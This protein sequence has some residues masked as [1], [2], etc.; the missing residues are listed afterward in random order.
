M[1]SY[2][3]PV[4]Y[5]LIVLFCHLNYCSQMYTFRRHILSNR[6]RTTKKSESNIF[7]ILSGTVVCSHDFLDN[8]N[9]D[10]SKVFIDHIIYVIVNLYVKIITR[11]CIVL[12]LCQKR[13]LCWNIDKL[14]LFYES[15]LYS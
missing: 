2:V 1:F 13:E 4:M 15:R 5:S 10:D 7:I 11:I 8:D 12:Y 6:V 14:F 3:G 9:K